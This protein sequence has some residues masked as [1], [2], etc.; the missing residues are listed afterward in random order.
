[1]LWCRFRGEEMYFEMEEGSLVSWV[2]DLVERALRLSPDHATSEVVECLKDAQSV[3]EIE[4]I[5]NS[6]ELTGRLPE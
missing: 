6:L 2:A 5:L 3:E 4:E 1:M